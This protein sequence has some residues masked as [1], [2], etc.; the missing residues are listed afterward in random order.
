MCARVRFKTG[1]D[2][3]LSLH[4]ALLIVLPAPQS[5]PCVGSGCFCCHISINV[6]TQAPD[7]KSS[8]VMAIMSVLSH[9]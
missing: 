7:M 2:A 8:M 3:F 4:T 9:D 5:N 1:T 6:L